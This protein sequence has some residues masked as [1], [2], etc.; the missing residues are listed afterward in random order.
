LEQEQ[1]QC[2][3][4]EH[5]QNNSESKQ[6]V[7]EE[8]D[9]MMYMEEL[10]VVVEKLSKK[11]VVFQLD[12]KIMWVSYQPKKGEGIPSDHSRVEKL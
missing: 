4:R 11:I 8:K 10:V 12:H 3:Q 7:E 6:Q 1:I 2:L 5:L 9:E